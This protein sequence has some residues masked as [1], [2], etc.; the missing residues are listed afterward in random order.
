MEKARRILLFTGEGKGKTTAALGM[1]LRCYGH[2][3]PVAL[4]H[5]V[6][7]RRSVGEVKALSRLEGIEQHITGLGFL[8]SPE[9]PQ[10]QEHKRAAVEGLALARRILSA[11]KHYLIILDEICWAIYRNLFTE[12]EALETIAE[13]KEGACLVLTGRGASAA[14]IELADT[15][16]E[17]KC[18]KHAYAA[19]VAAQAGIEK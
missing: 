1:A 13:L 6:K 15:V 2:G 3:L 5:F 8:P 10:F 11:G 16:T 12:E 14:L 4:V 18:I 19:G 7:S 17:M 9:R